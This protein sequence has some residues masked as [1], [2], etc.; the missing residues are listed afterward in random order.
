VKKGLLL[1]GINMNGTWI[2]VDKRIILAF[3]VFSHPAVTAFPFV[4]MAET[5]TELTLDAPAIQFG[6][7]R[8]EFSS[9]KPLFQSLSMS[10]RVERNPV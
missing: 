10:L 4:N 1:D 8:G 2:A 5:G 7:V 9:Q 6:V 3:D